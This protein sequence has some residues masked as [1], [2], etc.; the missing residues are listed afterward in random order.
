MP[1]RCG[2]MLRTARSHLRPP[3]GSAA[4]RFSL[5][6][7]HRLVIAGALLGASGGCAGEGSA[8][9]TAPAAGAAAHQR[10]DAA[11]DTLLVG[12][13]RPGEGRFAQTDAASSGAT[14]YWTSSQALEAVLDGIERNGPARLAGIVAALYETHDREGWARDWFDDQSWMALSLLRAYDLLGDSRYLAR[15]VSLAEDIAANA[16]DRTCCGSV[17][18]GLW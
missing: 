16:P 18:G 3:G 2:G 6:A 7:W 14:G 4:A 1:V 9:S 12:Y 10:A 15:A 5:R 8:A 11:L 17:P 13:W